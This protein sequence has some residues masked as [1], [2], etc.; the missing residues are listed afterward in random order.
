MFPLKATARNQDIVDDSTVSSLIDSKIG[1]WNR[2][3][4][5]NLISPFV[6]QRIKA[7]PLCRTM[8]KTA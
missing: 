6:A 7:I 2:Q 8:Q 1:D 3:L 5:D 4:I